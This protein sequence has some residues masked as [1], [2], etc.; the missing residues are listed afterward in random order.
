MLDFAGG[1]FAL[2]SLIC[3]HAKVSLLPN[4]QAA[5]EALSTYKTEHLP[6]KNNKSGVKIYLEKHKALHTALLILVLLGTCMVI[7][8]GVLTP[9]ISGKSLSSNVRLICLTCSNL[10][11]CRL[12]YCLFAFCMQFFLLYLALSYPCP[13]SIISVCF[14]TRIC[15]ISTIKLVLKL[16]NFF[17]KK[18][19]FNRM[20]K[21]VALVEN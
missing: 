15:L 21:L 17:I 8:D 2:Y 1:T 3:R 11:V 12:T 10:S 19:G 14:F 16:I 5:D 7:G 4:R 20:T 6:E 9:A 18:L 13:R